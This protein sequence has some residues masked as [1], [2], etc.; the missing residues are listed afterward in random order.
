MLPLSTKTGSNAREK[1][2]LLKPRTVQVKAGKKRGETAKDSRQDRCALKIADLRLRAK[3]K[4]RGRT[5]DAMF[6]TY[7]IT[8]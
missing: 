2:R 4:S 7:T 5:K 6:K 1:D 8:L 3:K